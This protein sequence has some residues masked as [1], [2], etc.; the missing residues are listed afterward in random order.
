M[1]PEETIFLTGF[2]GFIAGRLV[3]RLARDGARFQLL[4]QPAFAERARHEV[5]RIALET[6]APEGNFRLLEGDITR[7]DLGLSARDL[8]EARGEATVVFHLAAVYD[9]AVS[10]EVG[11]RVNVEGTRN[12]NRFALGLPKLRRY[13]YVSTCYVAGRRTGVILES[14]L[15]HEEGFRNNYEETK[16]LAELEV[17]ALK[18]ELPVTIHRPSVVCGDSRTGE[19]AKYDGIY[20]LIQYLRISPRAL[21]LA[22]IGN[23]EVR[24]NVVPVDYVVEAMAALARDDRAA[25]ETVQL[26]DPAPLTTEE[27]FDLISRNLAGRES[28]LTVPAPL[29]RTTLNIPLNEKVTGLPRVG[30]PYFFLKQTYDT[31]RATALLEPR[32]VHCPRFPDYVPALLDFVERHPKI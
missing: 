5:A 3:E 2:P 15:R 20:Y 21:S 11:F 7:E 6:G 27:L 17:D 24:L 31:A 26:A 25:G 16:Y 23:S 12:V 29:V 30:V 32:G 14:E 8:E 10:R 4:V 9:L 19:T 22:N 18:R 1:P 13:H 28:L